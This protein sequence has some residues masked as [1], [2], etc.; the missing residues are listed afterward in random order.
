MLALQ[1]EATSLILK[2]KIRTENSDLH[3]FQKEVCKQ[4]GPQVPQLS[5]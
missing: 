3:N 1:S 5:F 4:K 2:K